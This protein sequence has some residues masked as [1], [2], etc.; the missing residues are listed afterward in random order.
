M[1]VEKPPQAAA[2]LKDPEAL[3]WLDAISQSSSILSMILAVIHSELH[4]VGWETFNWLRQS[5]KIQCQ[6]V[7][8]RWTSVFNVVS[9]I[10][11]H[12]TPLHWDRNSRRQWYDLLVTLGC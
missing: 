10:C 9:V 4:N 11:N 5:A 7:L 1:E 2:V 6:D 3:E 12:L 8:H